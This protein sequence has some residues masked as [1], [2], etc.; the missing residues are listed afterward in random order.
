MADSRPPFRADHVGSLLRP[1]SLKALRL[2]QEAGRVSAKCVT[3]PAATVSLFDVPVI[4]A[5][6]ESV[7]VMVSLPAVLNVSLK[8]P[9]PL[10]SVVSAGRLA[11]P[12]LEVKWTVPV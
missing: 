11:L 4:E 12:S 5:V 9:T 7:A 6:T 8:L 3:V 10:V 1:P 2:D